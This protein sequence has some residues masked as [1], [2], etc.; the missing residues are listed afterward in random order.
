MP[1][2]LS[3][4]A[5]DMIE[6]RGLSLSWI[7]QAV[8]IHDFARI[9][10][11]DPSVTHAF[12]SIAERDGRILKVVFRANGDDILVITTHFDRGVAP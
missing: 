9:D 11:H 6:Q 7:E 12:K 8:A 2:R 3:Q 10:R 5:Q 1:L 4:H